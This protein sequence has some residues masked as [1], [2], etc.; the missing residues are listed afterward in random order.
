M[1]NKDDLIILQ[2]K[3]A[4]VQMFEGLMQVSVSHVQQ[5]LEFI[6]CP[7]V[8]IAEPIR[9]NSHPPLYLPRLA[10]NHKLPANHRHAKP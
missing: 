1:R 3:F 7:Y 8:G 5:R 10:H 4:T 9:A 2:A 6:C